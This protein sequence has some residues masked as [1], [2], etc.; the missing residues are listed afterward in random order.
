V[1]TARGRPVIA[2]GH[3]WLL[4]SDLLLEALRGENIVPVIARLTNDRYPAV[5]EANR[6]VAIDKPTSQATPDVEA[7]TGHYPD[8]SSAVH[9]AL[10]ALAG[11]A[12]LLGCGGLLVD[13]VAAVGVPGGHQND[14][15]RKFDD[16]AAL[17]H[18]LVAELDLPAS[19]RNKTP[20]FMR[21]CS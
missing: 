16:V 6:R 5:T 2:G 19:D 4:A 9:V 14:G 8:A 7:L 18:D 21:I 3:S 10:S 13:D 1:T 11:R 15:E 17:V 20:K 12:V